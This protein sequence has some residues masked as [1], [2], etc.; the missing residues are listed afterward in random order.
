MAMSDEPVATSDDL[1][2]RAVLRLRKKREFQGHLITYLAVN[3]LLIVTW[4]LTGAGFFWP[5]FPLVA[6]GIGV[7][8]HGIDAYG[9]EPSEDR[10]RTEMDRLR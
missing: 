5:M 4:A 7:V 2:K 9:G 3:A 8:F 6:W 10:I 1:R